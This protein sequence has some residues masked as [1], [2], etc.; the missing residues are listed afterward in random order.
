ME[1]PASIATQP[2]RGAQQAAAD[3]A[4]APGGGVQRV[5]PQEGG[6]LQRAQAGLQGHGRRVLRVGGLRG[7]EGGEAGSC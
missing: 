7:G 3:L 2:S 6:A 4:E 1:T 5:L